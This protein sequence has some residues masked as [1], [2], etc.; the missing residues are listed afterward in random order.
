MLL[1][2]VWKILRFAINLLLQNQS[3]EINLCLICLRQFLSFKYDSSLLVKHKMA[4]Q[5]SSS[6]NFCERQHIVQWLINEKSFFFTISSKYILT[7]SF[8]SI[9]K[10][11]CS[12]WLGWSWTQAKQFV[13][14]VSGSNFTL[15][16]AIAISLPCTSNS[17]RI[18][19]FTWRSFLN[20]KT[21]VISSYTGE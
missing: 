8:L 9:I 21:M 7:N 11:S 12:I 14:M 4:S 1:G 13:C 10:Q 3:R 20:T 5:I 15:K 18:S 17:F 16:K 2:Y 19:F 6:G